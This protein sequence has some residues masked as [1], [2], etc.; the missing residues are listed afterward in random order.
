MSM[1]TPNPMI[2][3]NFNIVTPNFNSKP[4]ENN[5]LESLRKLGKFG[6][7]SQDRKLKLYGYI[8]YKTVFHILKSFE[9]KYLSKLTEIFPL[10]ILKK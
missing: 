2:T 3:P 5:E 9:K 1:G 6:L 10:R 8:K 7:R 4:T